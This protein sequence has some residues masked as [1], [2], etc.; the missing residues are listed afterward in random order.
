MLRA[1]A[2]TTVAAVAFGDG[3]IM[4]EAFREISPG[5]AARSA[6]GNRTGSCCAPIFSYLACRE[7]SS[8]RIAGTFNWA[9]NDSRRTVENHRHRN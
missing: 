8:R 7:T 3:D 4:E 1:H 9:W 2:E 5:P 6:S